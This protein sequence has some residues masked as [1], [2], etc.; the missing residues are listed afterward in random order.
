MNR[1]A[2]T[3]LFVSLMPGREGAIADEPLRRLPVS[4]HNCYPAR[5]ADNT[6]L[7]EALRLGIDN[8]EIDLGWDDSN[9]RLIVGHDPAPRPDVVYPEFEAYL[10]PAL[11]AHWKTHV[12]GSSPTVLTIDWKTEKPEAVAKFKAF[13]D[14]RPQWFTS[15][16]KSQ[17]SPLTTRRLTV[18]LTG[19]E[20]AKEAYD[21]LIPDGGTY[22]AFRDRVFGQGGKFETD[23]SA[24][25]P[26]KATAYHRFMTYHWGVVE[27]GGPALAKDWTGLDALR[28]DAIVSR[29]HNQ[30][31]RVRFYCLNGHTG[32][33]L[34]GYQFTSDDA[35]K[36]R[37][38]AAARAGV[39]WIASDEYPEIAKALTAND[40][41]VPV[42]VADMN[43]DETV[44]LPLADD[45]L[46]EVRL[47]SVEVTF[48]PIRDA[49]RGAKVSLTVNGTAITIGTG[50]YELPRRV[51][52]VQVDCPVISAYNRNSTEDHWGLAK[53]A[54][55]R[56]WPA[57]KPWIDPDTF[58][59]PA[60]QA[61][62]AS[63]T[64]MA[65]EP[66]YVDGG[67]I[68]KNRQIYYHSGLDIGG[69]E[70]LAEVIA[71]TD[72][73]VVSSGTDQLPGLGD[74][75][76]EVR[77]DVVCIRDSRGWYYRYSH[78]KTID[79]AIKPGVPVKKS[80]K[81]GLLGKEGG[82]GGWSHLH[83]EIKSLMPSGKWGTQEGYAFLWQ[84]AI[85][86]QERKVVAV[87][88]PHRFARVGDTIVL[89][90]SKSWA[91]SGNVSHEWTLS[92]G[93]GAESAKVERKYDRPGEYSEI[94][95]VT[96]AQGHVSYDFAVVQVIDPKHPDVLSP[97]IHAAYFPTAGLKAGDEVTFKTRTFRVGDDGG[98]E[99][100]DFGDGSP[101]T[102][103][104]SD[105]NAEPHAPE[106][107]AVFTHRF[108]KPGD[109]LIRIDR[110]SK[111]G[112]NATARLHVR[113]E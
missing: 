112:I 110:A 64:Q 13:L 45:G 26:Q 57:D 37:W 65:N 105:G 73:L 14:A 43:T 81:I 16:P 93:N 22:R 33:L 17:E 18:C 24:Y 100:V 52:K 46:A 19:S 5:S 86:E 56:V 2:W 85:R 3:I 77:A 79:A 31:F 1:I 102:S 97:T 68:P 69:A 50:N 12:E 74:L 106:G 25:V 60:R 96:D 53:A 91:L 94:L 103:V 38:L 11:E 92:N 41:S 42:A 104:K 8:I 72:G 55:V 71:A 54:R 51:G 49:V 90:G 83:F 29:A 101:M 20:A 84:A 109:Y 76:V 4:A 63:M 6:K 82:S 10:V 59:F 113:V 32:T 40:T 61:W 44:L 67:E 99:F 98:G 23:V 27:Q 87:A 9:K 88:R 78:L 30:G 66:V 111:A 75:P 21:A 36:T 62:L 35:A 107:Y 58:A 108:K 34:S 7:V 28:L 39:D 80:Q 89:D 70:G 15:A 95:K 48:D 47:D